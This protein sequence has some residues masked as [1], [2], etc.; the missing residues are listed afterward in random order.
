MIQ[1]QS[2]YFS[3]YWQYSRS[4]LPVFNIS[5]ILWL[6]FGRDEISL[7]VQ[8][9]KKISWNFAS[10]RNFKLIDPQDSNIWW[11]CISPLD[12]EHEAL[13]EHLR[14][15]VCTDIH[16]ML[17]SSPRPLHKKT[18]LFVKQRGHPSGKIW[19]YVNHYV[20]C[21]SRRWKWMPLKCNSPL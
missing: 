10:L 19:Y 4:S 13:S 20:K 12:T 2:S 11:V 3:L 5:F 14:F 6:Y 9:Q 16:S 8:A 18:W 15:S 21:T 7:E 17:Y 1:F